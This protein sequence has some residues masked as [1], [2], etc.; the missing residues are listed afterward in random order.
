MVSYLD[1]VGKMHTPT[2]GNK[3]LDV[4]LVQMNSLMGFVAD[5]LTATIFSLDISDLKNNVWFVYL[6][7]CYGFKMI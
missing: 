3:Q 6:A 1:F 7:S 2:A 5:A 4:P